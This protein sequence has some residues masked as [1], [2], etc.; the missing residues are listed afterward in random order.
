MAATYNNKSPWYRTKKFP[1]YLGYLNARSI[2]AEPDDYLYSIEPQYNYRPDLLAYDLYG[3]TKLW[4]VFMQRNM[5]VIRDPLFDF[6]VGTQIYIPKK[7]SLFEVLG[8]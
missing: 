3:S 6:K 7:S 5:D 8:I 1:G 4:W 2:S